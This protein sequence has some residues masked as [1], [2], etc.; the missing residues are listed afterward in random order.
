MVPVLLVNQ[1]H[2][3]TEQHVIAIQDISSFREYA[4]LALKIQFGMVMLANAILDIS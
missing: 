2:I 3:Q 4:R 1:I